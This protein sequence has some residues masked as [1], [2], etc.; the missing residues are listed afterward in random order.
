MD[1][2]SPVGTLDPSASA[3]ARQE[4]CVATQGQFNLEQ[5]AAEPSGAHVQQVIIIGRRTPVSMNV[6]A[7][8]AMF[9][10][11]I[12]TG[13]YAT[14]VDQLI[15]SSND[16]SVSSGEKLAAAIDLHERVATAVMVGKMAGK[17]AEGLQTVVTKSG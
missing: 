13:F 4:R 7:A 10:D 15:S 12:R 17:L 3:A 2:I 14:Q 16:P 6:V 8:G 1:P 11:R 5:C 9:S